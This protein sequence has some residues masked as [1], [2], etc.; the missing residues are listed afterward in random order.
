MLDKKEVEVAVYQWWAKALTKFLKEHPTEIYYGLAA[1]CDPYNWGIHLCLGTDNPKEKRFS[2]YSDRS[3]EEI[4]NDPNK[5]NYESF[6]YNMRTS[7]EYDQHFSN[8]AN[9]F[10]EQICSDDQVTR[11]KVF[12]F[13]IE[14]LTQ[15]MISI[16]KEFVIGSSQFT[17]PTDIFVVFEEEDT[18]LAR[19]RYQIMK[20]GNLESGWSNAIYGL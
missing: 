15:A 8:Y 13:F 20:N 3:P 17:Q 10:V 2:D 4:K 6:D 12:E 9:K 7:D 16:E 14:A 11:R 1:V 19:E 18:M 5:W